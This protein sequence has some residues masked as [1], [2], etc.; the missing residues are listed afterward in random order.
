[1]A[2][3][4]VEHSNGS[5]TANTGNTNHSSALSSQ[6]R[7]T[8]NHDEHNHTYSNQNQANTDKLNLPTT[9][10]HDYAN[11]DVSQVGDFRPFTPIYVNSDDESMRELLSEKGSH[12]SSRTK[13]GRGWSVG[14][15]HNERVHGNL[16][17]ELRD[18]SAGARK[19]RVIGYHAREGR[20]WSAGPSQVDRVQGPQMREERGRSVGSAQMERVN[21]ERS[22]ERRNWFSKR[23][24]RIKKDEKRLST[25]VPSKEKTQSQQKVNTKRPV[26]AHSVSAAS[27]YKVDHSAE[28]PRP[29]SYSNNLSTV[30]S[31]PLPLPP[32]SVPPPAPLLRRSN[33]QLAN[34][35]VPPP[36]HSPAP[37]PRESLA[38]PQRTSAI[39]VSGDYTAP[40]P[41]NERYKYD[42]KL[43]HETAEVS[44]VQGLF[45]DRSH[46]YS[47]P[48]EPED[49]LRATNRY[50]HL[51]PHEADVHPE[52]HSQAFSDLEGLKDDIALPYTGGYVP[53][54]V[55]LKPLYK[56]T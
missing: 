27:R 32:F 24:E 48:D 8:R 1:M 9:C 13:E 16:P 35:L 34:R 7:A 6:H 44:S 43:R 54:E 14:S 53:T 40:V 29:R 38:P 17:R 52:R 49:E 22:K 37:P 42:P 47:D 25:E 20:G 2:S 50:D 41:V 55:S 31:K 10:N 36:T 30:L 26:R 4:S 3:S 18:W 19:D 51:S 5:G 28:F 56:M 23:A 11:A 33:P 21:S 45:G 46:D 39:E 12:H 15:S